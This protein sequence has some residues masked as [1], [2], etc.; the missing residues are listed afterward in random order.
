ARQAAAVLR[1]EVRRRELRL[2]LED[3]FPGRER[4]LCAGASRHRAGIPQGS[5]APA[6][7]GMTVRPAQRCSRLPNSTTS[8]T[9][10]FPDWFEVRHSWR[11]SVLSQSSRVSL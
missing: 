3:R 9:K 10:L 7:R 2:R 5:E 6:R 1:I 4:G 11:Y 8:A